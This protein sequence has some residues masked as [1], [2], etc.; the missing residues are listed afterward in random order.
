MLILPALKSTVTTYN[1]ICICC[2]FPLTTKMKH[3]LLFEPNFKKKNYK[4]LFQRLLP[5]SCSILPLQFSLYTQCI[6][7][8]LVIHLCLGWYLVIQHRNMFMLCPYLLTLKFLKMNMLSRIGITTYDR[9]A[10]FISWVNL[11]C[12]SSRKTMWTW[13]T[14][15]SNHAFVQTG[16]YI[17]YYHALD[18]CLRAICYSFYKL[19]TGPF[20]RFWLQLRLSP[21]LA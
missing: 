1:P 7:I 15:M 19:L 9:S 16:K 18:L 11:N 4:G 21:F 10:A 20:W 5:S 13:Q 8:N 3:S 14:Y 12:K 2:M 6:W 17:K